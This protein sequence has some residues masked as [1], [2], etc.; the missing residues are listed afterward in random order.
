MFN[1]KFIGKSKMIFRVFLCIFTLVICL[2][3]LVTDAKPI[4]KKS[5]M[6][7]ECGVIIKID[8]RRNTVTFQTQNGNM[9]AF[10]GTEDFLVGD[11][12]AVIMD[13]N[14]TPKV[15]DDKIMDVKYSGYISK[16]EMIK[17]VK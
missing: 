10:Y 12:V 11:L 9:F 8:K 14:G 3:T 15:S 6:Y 4:K 16:I 1:G 17:W 13:D 5:Q 2:S 7:P